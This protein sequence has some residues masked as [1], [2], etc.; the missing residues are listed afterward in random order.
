MSVKE[1]C[2]YMRVRVH[3]FERRMHLECIKLW[4]QIWNDA[5]HSPRYMD[6]SYCICVQSFMVTLPCITLNQ[7]LINWEMWIRCGVNGRGFT[8]KKRP[9]AHFQL[10]SHW[11]RLS[12]KVWL[13]WF[14]CQR[15]ENVFTC[16][17][18]P[19]FLFYFLNLFLTQFTVSYFSWWVCAFQ[20]NF[21][22]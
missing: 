17:E 21:S 20:F 15:F 14:V 16:R 2:I 10:H 7:T 4:T 1:K 13:L 22:V 6:V 12:Q 3:V 11:R 18:K 8:N 5:S 9:W 19:Y